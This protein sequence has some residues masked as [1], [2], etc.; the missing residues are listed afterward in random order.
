MRPGRRKDCRHARTQGLHAGRTGPRQDRG[1][2]QLATYKRLAD[3]VADTGDEK[4]GAA[5]DAFE[6]LMFNNMTI[7]LDRYFVHRLSESSDQRTSWR[8]RATAPGTAPRMA[9]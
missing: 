2:A 8:A 6:P 1:R 9:T 5:L 3:A 4:A 7:V